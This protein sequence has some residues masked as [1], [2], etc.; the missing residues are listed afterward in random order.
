MFESKTSD[1][2]SAG[3]IHADLDAFYASVEQRDDPTLRGR[4]II[5]GGGIVLAA[6]YEAKRC[7]VRTAMGC[8][9]ALRLCPQALIVPPR[10]EAYTK[11]SR[12]VF[13][14]FHDVTP[15]VEGISIDEAF[16]DVRGLRRLSGTPAQIGSRLRARVLAEVGLP[17]TV[18]IARTKF[19]AK[20]ASRVA[21]PDGLLLVPPENELTFLHPLPVSM[22][23]G[24]GPKTCAKLA[25]RGIFTV[26][27][28]TCLTTEDLA[29]MVGKAAGRQL[30][31]LSRNLDPRPVQVGRRRRS[32]GSQSASGLRTHRAE[33]VD[34]ILVAIVD[35]VARR[36]REAERIGRT[37]VVRMRFA[38]YTRATRSHTLPE[39]TART[40]TLLG[41]ARSLLRSA[42]PV[43]TGRG[44]LTMVGLSV[45]D[46]SDDD[47]VQMALPLIGATDPVALDLARDAV[48]RK[49]GTRALTRGV[50]VGRHTGYEMPKLPD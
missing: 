46:L 49:F 27:D 25:E 20:V 33:D 23:W 11:A 30:F 22:L 38:D 45:A 15:M 3:I 2:S 17:I 21:K 19:L 5:V 29:A 41:V 37:V 1:P 34:A 24:V 12:D 16:L 44:G 8:T 42:W 14:V 18:G 28:T 13:D 10:F 40:E 50:L 43:V 36:M 48:A 32:I 7:G 35:R 6:S 4:P 47:V 39:P 26:A 9:A 31:C